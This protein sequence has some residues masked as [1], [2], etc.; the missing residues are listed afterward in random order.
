MVWYSV[1]IY[2]YLHVY[3]VDE[4]QITSSSL[5]GIICEEGNI[6]L[7]N[8]DTTE[9][10]LVE[11]CRSGRWAAI[12]D[13]EWT[14]EDMNVIC[15]QAG[16]STA[17]TYI[18]RYTACVGGSVDVYIGLLWHMQMMVLITSS[19]ASGHRVRGSLM[20]TTE[21]PMCTG[22]ETSL[23][24]C[25]EAVDNT[26]CQYLELQCANTGSS[27][28][29]KNASSNFT[30][31]SSESVSPVVGVAVGVAVG[32]GFGLLLTAVILGSAVL[33]GAAVWKRR[34]GSMTFSDNSKPM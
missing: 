9:Y 22:T 23:S 31:A 25:F 30:N 26:S 27:G 18:H 7:T 34:R 21:V 13:N 4:L 20:T 11:M 19:A 8:G 29:T 5:G 17:G 6:Q 15:V 32:V 24:Q 1:C 3:E 33:A 28:S 2:E 12:C 16:N 14:M 10:S